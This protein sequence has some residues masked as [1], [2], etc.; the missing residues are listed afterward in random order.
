MKPAA[1]WPVV[2]FHHALGKGKVHALDIAGALV[3]RG[4]A[5]IASDA[6]FHGERS[7]CTERAHCV[8]PGTCDEATGAC[9]TALADLDSDGIPDASGGIGRGAPYFNTDNPFAIRDNIRQTVVDAA[10][11]LR[12]VKLGGADR[13]TGVGVQSIPLLDGDRVH[14]LGQSLGGIVGTMLLAVDS[15]PQRGVLSVPGGP[16][17]FGIAAQSAVFSPFVAEI[18]KARGVEPGSFEELQ[19]LTTFQWILDAAD[20]VSFAPFVKTEQLE[21]PVTQGKVT[22]KSVIVQKAA[23]D[24]TVP[25]GATQRLADLIGVSTTRTTFAGQ[26]H[27]FLLHPSPDAT[28]TAAAQAQAALFLETGDVCVPKLVDGT[29]TVP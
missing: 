8:A 3:A 14:F 4:F 23:L 22:A 26:D 16:W 7:R 24:R 21:D 10:A 5:V 27:G 29:C 17:V 2:Y 15:L 13:L 11:L 1:G 20:A 25:A 9:S 28:A 18:A 6:P 19:I 12:A